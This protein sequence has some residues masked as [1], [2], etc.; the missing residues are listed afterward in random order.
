MDPLTAYG[1]V[2]TAA[3]AFEPVTLVDAKRYLRVT[4][5]EEDTLIDGLIVTARE[6]A[7]HYLNLSLPQQSYR[8]TLADSAPC[9]LP[10]PRPPGLSIASVSLLP[11]E[12]SATVVDALTYE[13]DVQKRAVVFNVA[14]SANRIEV[15]YTAGHASASAI[16][17][18]MVLGVLAHVAA[19]YECRG[20]LQAAI[21]R[22]SLAFYAPFREVR[23]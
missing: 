17:R 19:L 16:P 13:V 5:T 15:L 8:L 14:P 12:G 4:H 20:D 6:Q 22:E 1:L 11:R 23:V 3:P 18:P 9:H 2:R 10:L 7:E 21:P